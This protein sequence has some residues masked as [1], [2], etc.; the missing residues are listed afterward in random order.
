MSKPLACEC[1]TCRT[2]SKRE[3][4]RE[5]SRKNRQRLAEYQRDYRERNAERLREQ[6][7]EYRAENAERI[8][9]RKAADYQRD[10]DKIR[11]LRRTRDRE[12][13]VQQA[14]DWARRNPEKRR[15]ISMR[16]K[17]RRRGAPLDAT[18]LEYAA[19]L[20]GDPCAYCGAPC[21]HIDHV[22]PL[23]GGGAS[24]WDNLTAA[25][26]SCNASKKDKPL[27]IWMA[28]A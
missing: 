25:C 15:D 10:K 11:E 22:E 4:L 7:A 24:E 14:V 3:Y 23:A 16:D 2:C 6:K 20:R 17:A 19:I 13:R 18:A 8:R 1:G 9:A 5:Y 27:L 21:A 28:T 26:A 12:I